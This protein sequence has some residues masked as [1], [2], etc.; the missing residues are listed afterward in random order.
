MWGEDL[1]RAMGVGGESGAVIALGMGGAKT[2]PTGFLRDRGGAV[3]Y[4]AI[5]AEGFYGEERIIIRTSLGVDFDGAF[6]SWVG[7]IVCRVVFYREASVIDGGCAPGG[8]DV[9]AGGDSSCYSDGFDPGS[10]GDFLD[11]GEICASASEEDGSFIVVGDE[12]PDGSAPGISVR[13]RGGFTGI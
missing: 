2:C 10:L 13:D 11:G 6:F 1:N 7:V 8:G 4:D 9:C 3:M 5:G 12:N